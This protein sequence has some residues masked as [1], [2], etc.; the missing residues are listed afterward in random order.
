M[1]DNQKVD[2]EVKTNVAAVIA[3]ITSI[4]SVLV[5]AFLIVIGVLGL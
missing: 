3:I 2:V 4:F 1:S 5:G